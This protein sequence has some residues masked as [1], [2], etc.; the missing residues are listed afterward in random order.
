MER[1]R[2]QPDLLGNLRDRRQPVLQGTQIEAG[3]ADDDR[4]APRL[5]RS[6]DLVERQR[7]PARGGPAIG[8][9]EKA[10][11]A[12]RRARQCGHVRTRGQDVQVA[13][14]LQAVGIDDRAVQGLRQR[15]GERRFAACG[16]AGDDEDRLAADF[17][18]T[19]LR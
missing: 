3:A 4:Q 15:Q 19:A 10:V 12:M 18:A 8:S 14:A 11:E 6:R 9:I 2:L 13:V 5:L 1:Q 16:R 17:L 7:T